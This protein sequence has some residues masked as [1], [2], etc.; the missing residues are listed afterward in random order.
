VIG[1]YSREEKRLLR[2]TDWVFKDN[3]LCFAFKGLI[4]R[5][6]IHVSVINALFGT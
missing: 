6:F 3:S 4:M 5:H 1:F 2:G